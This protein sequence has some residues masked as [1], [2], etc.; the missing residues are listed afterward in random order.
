MHGKKLRDW[1]VR[2]RQ[3]TVERHLHDDTVRIVEDGGGRQS[4]KFAQNESSQ[5][6]KGKGKGKGKNNVF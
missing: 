3:K 4:T 5:K 2:K 6:S 1:Q